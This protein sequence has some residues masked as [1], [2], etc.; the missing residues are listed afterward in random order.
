MKIQIQ[1]GIEPGSSDVSQMLYNW[2]TG[3]LALTTLKK[4]KQ[5]KSNQNNL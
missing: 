1:L 2:A 4:K 5:K 3:T